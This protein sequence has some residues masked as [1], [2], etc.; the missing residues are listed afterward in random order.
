M[1]FREYSEFEGAKIPSFRHPLI[2]GDEEQLQQICVFN[3][4]KQ[5]KM[6]SGLKFVVKKN[7]DNQANTF[8]KS[9]DLRMDRLSPR[10]SRNAATISSEL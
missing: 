2:K 8:S 10:R 9:K 1:F 4:L 6:T 5:Q 3:E 7:I